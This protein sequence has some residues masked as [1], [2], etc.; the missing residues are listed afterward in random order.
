[1]AP[2]E[3]VLVTGAGGG[4]GMHGVQLAKLAGAFTIGVTTSAA[5]AAR[6]RAAGADEVVV[7]APGED[8]SAAVKALTGGEGVDVAIDNVGSPVFHAV[9]RSLAACGRFVL[10]GQITGDFISLKPAQLFL[11]NISLLSAKG[12]SRRQLAAALELVQAGR[13][14]PVVSDVLPLDA[15]AEAH[16]AVE[17][18]G[19][20]GRIVL[21]P[22]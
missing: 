1:V 22:R 17:S 10:V 16:R 5:K 11:R 3:R 12:V 7:T 15:A 14:A 13:V 19:V 21:T 4:L 6:I 18:G 2:G 8:F 20:L 9:R